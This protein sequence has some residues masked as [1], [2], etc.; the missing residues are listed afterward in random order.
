MV[1]S[2]SLGGSDRLDVS[3][4]EVPVET[5]H[6]VEHGGVG[7]CL[8]CNFT[9]RVSA[10]ISRLR[11][12]RSA[13]QQP[14][15]PVGRREVNRHAELRNAIY[16]SLPQFRPKASDDA[17]SATTESPTGSISSIRVPVYATARIESLDTL[18]TQ[19]SMSTATLIPKPTSENDAVIA[20]AK[21]VAIST[22]AA[23]IVHA[24]HVQAN[25]DHYKSLSNVE[26]NLL[27]FLKEGPDKRSSADLANLAAV[28]R[29]YAT[30]I[31]PLDEGLPRSGQAG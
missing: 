8:P 7:G 26:T 19:R 13:G 1:N 15:A 27:N 16:G 11:P 24:A 6:R 20:T 10:W 31:A 2:V 17:P 22:G 21:R 3:Q 23:T 25:S 5:R 29:F 28:A 12:E 14:V 30:R 4:R 18:V 9:A